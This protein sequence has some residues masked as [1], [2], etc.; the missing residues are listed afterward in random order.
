M[1]SGFTNP[2]TK[3]YSMT[4]LEKVLKNGAEANG[5][6]ENGGEVNK[7][8]DVIIRG[9]LSITVI[10]AEDLAPADIMGKADPY[11]VLTMKKSETKNK[12]RVSPFS[13]IFI[14]T[15]FPLHTP[16]PPHPK[17]MHRHHF[18]TSARKLWSISR[19]YIVPQS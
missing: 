4:S 8:K 5:A 3:T 9:V 19:T 7:R 14:L 1:K 2:F 10:S 16:P 13:L 12:T 17:S 18:F 15:V 11:V 6:T